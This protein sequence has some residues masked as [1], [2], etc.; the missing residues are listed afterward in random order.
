MTMKTLALVIGNNNYLE[1]DRVKLNNAVNDATA[2]ADTF[3]R[4]DYD[5]IFRIDCTPQN[6][7]EALKEFNEKIQEADSAIFYYAGHGFQ[8]EGENYLTSIESPIQTADKFNCS[9]SSIRL[10][11]IL[12]IFEKSPTKVNIAIIDACRKSFRRGASSTFTVKNAPNGTLIAFSTSPGDGANDEGM[13]GH[14]IYTGTLLKYIGRENISVENL[15]KKVRKTINNLTSG[16]QTSWEHTSLVGDFYFNRGQLVYSPSIPYDE[17][18]VKD[19]LYVPKGEPIDNIITELKSCDWNRQNPA[20]NKLTRIDPDSISKDQQFILGRNIHQAG[21]YAREAINFLN[22]IERKLTRYSN[23]HNNHVLNG[24]LFEIYFDNNGEFRKTNFK[25]HSIE[26]IF[27]LRHIP[28][29]KKSFEF[30]SN[31]LSPFKEELFYIPIIE[32]SH[33]EVDVLATSQ[34]IENWQKKMKNFQVIES[35]KVS[36]IEISAELSELCRSGDDLEQ[37]KKCLAEY[38]V[39]P[40]E[41]IQI[42]ENMEIK[43]LEFRCKLEKEDEFDF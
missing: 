12:E 24:I 30:I 22:D 15:F 27:A 11:E 1:S 28:E 3:N 13:E 37:L 26:K 7:N 42:N 29:F 41:L 5:V 18:V 36:N 19:R 4:L 35:I 43:R 16:S 40:I 9:R 31:A 17:S 6:Y 21:G 39:A 20:M 14:S 8:F 38:L 34:K 33:L 23:D 2:I 32:D 10:S 25:L